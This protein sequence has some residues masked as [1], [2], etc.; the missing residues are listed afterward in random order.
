MYDNITSCSYQR[1]DLSNVICILLIV[2]YHI[3]ILK[4]HIIL[5]LQASQADMVVDYKDWQIPLGRRFRYPLT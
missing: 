5:K 2:V 4:F 1:I 3:Y